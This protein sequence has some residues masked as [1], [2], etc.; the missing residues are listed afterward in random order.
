MNSDELAALMKETMRLRRTIEVLEADKQVM[1]TS[2]LMLT[3]RLETLEK[4]KGPEDLMEINKTLYDIIDQLV[5]LQIAEDHLKINRK[6]CPRCSRD[7]DDELYKKM[8]I[9]DK[10]LMGAIKKIQYDIE[11][12]MKS[13]KQ[14]REAEISLK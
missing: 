14:K 10:A 1:M 5:F 9:D 2:N 8:R 3:T 7:I 13:L 11:N 12:K 6:I 4:I